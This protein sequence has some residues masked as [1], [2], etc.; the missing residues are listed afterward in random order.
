MKRIHIR[1]LN[2]LLA[3][4][5]HISCLSEWIRFF[6]FFLVSV[7]Q[8]GMSCRDTEEGEEQRE[9]QGE[10]HKRKR[11]STTRISIKT[12]QRKVKKER[13]QAIDKKTAEYNKGYFLSIPLRLCA[14][15]SWIAFHFQSIEKL[16]ISSSLT[17]GCLCQWDFTISS[18]WPIKNALKHW[19]K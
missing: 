18:T 6:S 11:G 13:E 9:R 16:I 8:E 1:T 14:G 15:V 10:M 19:T 17:I 4:P 7:R 3:G 12:K 5:K 2:L